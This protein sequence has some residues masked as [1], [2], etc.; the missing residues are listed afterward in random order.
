MSERYRFDDDHLTR[1]AEFCSLFID[2]GGPDPHLKVVVEAAKRLDREDALWLVYCYM[3][4]YTIGGAAVLYAL[5][6]D[7]EDPREIEDLISEHRPGIPLRTER[8][9]VYNPVKLTE[10]LV[11]GR[12]W[13][14]QKGPTGLHTST[15]D[16]LWSTSRSDLRF[17]G[18]YAAMKLL[19]TLYYAGL[20]NLARQRDIRPLGAWSPRATL[21]LLAP[22]EAQVLGDKRKNP[23]VIAEVNRIAHA[24]RKALAKK[25]GIWEL[26][27]FVYE[28]LLCNYR[29]SLGKKGKP[30]GASHDSELRYW[31]KARDYWIKSDHLSIFD[32]AYGVMPF[33][34][35]REE[36]FHERVLGEKMGWWGLKRNEL[37][38]L[39]ETEGFYWS[40]LLYDYNSTTNPAR[41]VRWES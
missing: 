21:A 11:S 37:N 14:R 28:T 9:A 33:Y 17:V 26:D 16:D 27:F 38:G 22:D 2:V 3:A 36:L 34:E 10:C 12:E 24:V 23:Q 19:G 39:I 20:A 7:V 6:R 25:M 5:T 15:Y 41:P 35:I 13:L 40:D 1:F 30:I 32:R 18:R 8:R 31:L 29:Q 4:V